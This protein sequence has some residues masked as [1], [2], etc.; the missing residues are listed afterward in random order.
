MKAILGTMMAVAI[1]SSTGRGE[2]S[3]ANESEMG[4]SI[5]SGNSSVESNSVKHK[6]TYVSDVN[7]YKTWGRY[8]Q[9]RTQGVETARNWEANLRYERALT[10]D[11][12]L[13]A[14]QG[15]ESDIF[16]GYVQRLNTDI[17][18]KYMLSKTE[19]SEWFAEVGYRYQDTNFVT[20]T[21]GVDRSNN[22][23]RAYTEYNQKFGD[24]VTAKL[25]VEYI[26]NFKDSEN[27]L[28]NGEPSIAVMLNQMFSLKSSYLA[29]YANPSKATRNNRATTDT[30]FLT[31]LVAKF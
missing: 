21:A 30:T 5:T 2:E 10:G 29:R 13:F 1:F 17:G 3:L 9:S 4:I 18:V 25:W 16:S 28:L 12:S 23:G 7:T 15:V 22:A 27:W 8:L 26:P 19:T 24:S 20:Q 31:S 6:T 14:Q 11:W